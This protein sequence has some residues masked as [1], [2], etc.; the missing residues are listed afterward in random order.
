MRSKSM[1]INKAFAAMFLALALTPTV[2]QATVYETGNQLLR[3]LEDINKTGFGP[4]YALGYIVGA[5]D[6]YGGASLCI[7]P[8]VTKGQLNDVVHAFLKQEP[9]IRHLPADVL[10][11]VAL[12]N[13]WACPKETK[14]KGKV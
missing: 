10:V 13:H 1:T 8:S 14:K 12:G 3:D 4:S 11:L 6:A 9:G 7:P 2:S 5:A